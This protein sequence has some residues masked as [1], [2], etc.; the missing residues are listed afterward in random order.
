M[1]Y[2]DTHVVVWLYEKRLGLLTS[3]AKK[4]IET[5]DL[6]VSPMVALELDYLKESG[7]ITPGSPRILEYLRRKLGLSVCEKPFLEV[8]NSACRQIWTR[9][10]FDRLIVGHAS[11]HQNS[12]LTKDEHIHKHYKLAVW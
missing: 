1:I 12:L 4:R 6:F 2:L 7:R 10:P 3:S 9:D 5:E 11:L 8:I